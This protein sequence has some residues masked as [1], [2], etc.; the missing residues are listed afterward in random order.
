MIVIGRKDRAE[1]PT[2]GVRNVPVKIDSG[3]YSCSIHCDYVQEELVN[4]Q[5]VC[6]ALYWRDGLLD[7]RI[8]F[9]VASAQVRRLFL[10]KLR[11]DSHLLQSLCMQGRCLPLKL[12]TLSMTITGI[13]SFSFHPSG[14]IHLGSTFSTGVLYKQAKSTSNLGRCAW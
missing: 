8:H 12:L 5:L 9:L 2:L 14:N 13:L 10:T 6:M 3:A 1:L 11:W 7:Q 4:D